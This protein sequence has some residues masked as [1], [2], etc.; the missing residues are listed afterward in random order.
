MR[1]QGH[2]C[3]PDCNGIPLHI[4]SPL[5]RYILAE[6]KACN[7]FRGYSRW[8]TFCTKRSAELGGAFLYISQSL[9]RIT[10]QLIIC[11]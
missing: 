3:H 10:Q 1:R 2:V 8:P 9:Q 4:L 6:L 11:L 5:S 7:T